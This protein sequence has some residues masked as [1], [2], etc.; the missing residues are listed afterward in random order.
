MRMV[1][2][3]VSQHSAMFSLTQDGYQSD[4]EKQQCDD[5]IDRKPLARGDTLQQGR[6]RCAYSA[7][8][9]MFGG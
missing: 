9:S 5:D 3:H 7:D 6:P 2:A 8:D 1:Q 4:Q